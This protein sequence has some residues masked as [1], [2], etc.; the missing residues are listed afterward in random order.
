MRQLFLLPLGSEAISFSTQATPPLHAR[1]PE[2]GTESH[3][4][5]AQVGELRLLR[6]QKGAGV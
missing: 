2:S 3:C 6:K 5:N 4:L 1:I